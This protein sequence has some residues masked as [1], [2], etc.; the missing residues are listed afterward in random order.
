MLVLAG[1]TGCISTG[2]SGPPTPPPPA[3]L[4]SEQ[5]AAHVSVREDRSEI[6]IVAGPFHVPATTERPEHG[7]HGAQDEHMKSPL[8]VVPWPVDAGLAGVR[9]AV[10]S[11]DGTPLPRDL[12]H[13]VIGVNFARRQLVYPVPE[14][15]FGFGTETPDVKLPGFLEVPLER[16]DSIGVY[17]MWNNTSGQDLHGVYLQVLI[18]YA[19]GEGE[20][21]KAFPIYL[22]T[23][24]QVGGKTSFDL[25]PGRSVRSY[26][27]TLPVGGG[28][29]AASGHLHDYGVELRL[30]EAATG[31]VVTRLEPEVDEQGHVTAVEQKIYRKLFK[32]I[33]D[34]LRLE[35]GVRYRVV[36]V[37]ENPTGESIPDGGMAHI[38]G[39]FVPDDPER[40]PELDPSN[41]LYQADVAALPAPIDGAHV[42]Y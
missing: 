28:L 22:D 40:W 20:R 11:A 3:M 6:E 41:A 25:P 26:E 5:P 35:A 23:N 29:L 39:L 4:R 1:A 13:H 21:E 30:E 38:V 33:D 19:D 31:R 2:F 10:Y 42:H 34:R 9:M 17:A 36:G 8:V 15:I 18:P 24:N 32:L 27:F 7:H 12:I 37:Y 16:G 14:R